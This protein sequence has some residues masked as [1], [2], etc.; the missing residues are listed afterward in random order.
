[1]RMFL[2]S[3]PARRAQSI[4]AQLKKEEGRERSRPS[5]LQEQPRDYF[6]CGLAPVDDE[7]AAPDEDDP[8][9]VEDD[10]L[11]EDVLGD[12][13][14]DDDP[15]GDDEDAPDEDEPLGEAAGLL[16]DEV[17]AFACTPSFE[18]VSVSIRPVAFRPSFCW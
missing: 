1:M 16:V 10:P 2:T 9:G 12:D 17:S 15:L 11:G 5:V 13:V 3:P 14:L 4:Q 6:V 18:A 7:P 8:L